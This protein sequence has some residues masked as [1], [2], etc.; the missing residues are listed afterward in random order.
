ML[1]KQIGLSKSRTYELLQIADGTK[2]VKE[3][4]DSSNRRSKAAQAKVADE[5]CPLISGQTD[6]DDEPAMHV[7]VSRHCPSPLRVTFEPDDAGPETKINDA[8]SPWTAHGVPAP[9]ESEDDI[10]HDIDPENYRSAFLLR[11][12]E[13]A[14]FATYSGPTNSEALEAARAA[15]T[16]WGQL[17]REMQARAAPDEKATHKEVEAKSID[18]D[19]SSPWYIP[20][21]LRRETEGA[22]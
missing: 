13:A 4:R 2:T 12:Y 21:E 8:Q 5:A 19:E 16:S 14:R 7:R 3:V 6:D 15:A 1:K 20:P 18:E 22:P 11:A 10:E 9:E 17:V